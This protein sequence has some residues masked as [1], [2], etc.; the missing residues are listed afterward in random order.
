MKPPVG[1]LSGMAGRKNILILCTDEYRGDLLACN[2]LNPDIRTP[3]MDALAASGVNF[4][5]H[6][7]TFPKCV[8]AR[9]SMM[10][11]RYTHTDGYRTIHQLM[12][13]GTPDLASTLQG[14]DYEL[15]ELGRNHCW[16]H[17]L[18]ASHKPPELEPGQEGI[19]FD[20]HAWTPP[21][22]AIWNKHRKL[23]EA[24]GPHA[25]EPA[26]L[27]EGRGFV[28]QRAHAD[29]ADEAVT[30]MAEHFMKDVRDSNRPF[31]LQVNIGK[32][33]P[34]YHADDPWFSMY[35]RQ[36]MMPFPYDLPSNAPLAV[37][38]QRAVRSGFDCPEGAFRAIQ[39]TY[40]GMCSKVDTLMGRLVQA[41]KDAGLWDETVVVLTSDH[42]DYAGQ[43]GLPEKWDAH[44]ADCLTHVPMIL[45]GGGLPEG[46]TVDSLTS[47]VDLAPTLCELTGVEP[48]AGI[49]GE[50]MTPA[51]DGEATR[52]AVFADGGHE[53]EMRQ[54]FEGV[55]RHSQAETSTNTPDSFVP[56][57]DSGK[58]K[59]E[60][61][62]LFPDTMAR[63]KMVR[64]ARWKLV[65]RETGDHELYDL[66]ADRWEMHNRYPEPGHDDVKQR[67][68]AKLLDW[69]LRTDTD[70]PHQARVGA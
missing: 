22:K 44:F 38:R 69:T 55:G 25:R 66:D 47:H 19:A 68:M 40:M 29:F 12:P 18:A 43:Y 30:E 16:E 45:A 51:M 52:D 35:D 3:H 20:Y 10:T 2:G 6:F 48:F 42:G 28:K 60:T 9:V 62:R 31:F 32:P 41:L 54:R 5:R 50:S 13:H 56:V 65:W 36:E 63:A 4:R 14:E 23:S 59:Q 26:T 39:S 7:T 58:G 17:M 8:P 61:Y 24:A 34:P 64:T 49:H 27:A 37:E 1:T 57:I 67:L 11:G 70:R 15:V 46:R 21:F 33:H 53:A